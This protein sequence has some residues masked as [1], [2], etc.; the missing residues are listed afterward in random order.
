MLSFARVRFRAAAIGAAAMLAATLSGCVA[1]TD[2][3]GH[4]S[5][6]VVAAD[7]GWLIVNFTINGSSD[8]EQC[9]QLGASVIGVKVVATNGTPAGEFR[10][11]CPAFYST[12]ALAAGSYSADVVL[13]DSAGGSRTS[14]VAL[15]GLEIVGGSPLEVPLDFATHTLYAPRDAF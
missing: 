1:Q 3:D 8:P 12:V 4:G 14:S 10:Q 5:E 7:S 15:Q 13:L 6:A 11:A 2:D 9:D